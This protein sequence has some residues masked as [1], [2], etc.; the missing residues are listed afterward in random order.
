MLNLN[1][2]WVGS[3]YDAVD[4]STLWM[5]WCDGNIY[6]LGICLS[7]VF[8]ST[9]STCKPLFSISKALIS[10]ISLYLF[11]NQDLFLIITPVSWAIFFI[12]A[13]N[14]SLLE[15]N[16]LRPPLVSICQVF[17]VLLSRSLQ[18]KVHI[19][20]T[21]AVCTFIFKKSRNLSCCA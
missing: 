10:N 18:G 6:P 16:W 19:S 9:V 7:G 21:T 15:E 11:S 17:K 13:S 12:L 14:I 8:G 3:W 1:I 20:I 2:W 4:G 5:C